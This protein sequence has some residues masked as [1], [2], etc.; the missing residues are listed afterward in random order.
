MIL[1]YL[2]LI[3]TQSSFI[4][5]QLDLVTEDIAIISSM[6]I[7]TMPP[8]ISFPFQFIQWRY[9]VRHF[10]AA[11]FIQFIKNLITF[12][13][14]ESKLNFLLPIFVNRLERVKIIRLNLRRPTKVSST[15]IIRLIA[16]TLG[17]IINIVNI[18]TSMFKTIFRFST[19]AFL[20]QSTLLQLRESNKSMTI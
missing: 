17:I 20:G 2:N 5:G 16:R 15:N 9:S 13:Y 11:S 18:A 7:R 3:K 12:G 6:R 8:A 4:N 10:N 19:S 1:A 14:I